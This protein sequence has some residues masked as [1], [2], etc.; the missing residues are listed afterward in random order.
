MAQTLARVVRQAVEQVEALTGREAEGV[1]STRRREDG[2]LVEVEVVETR[3]IPDTADLLAIY[4]VELD[5]EGEL[6]GYRRSRRYQRGRAD[7]D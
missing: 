7:D 1:T 4:E 2:W 3:R 5:D 6:T